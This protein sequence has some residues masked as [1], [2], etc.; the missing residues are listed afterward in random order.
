MFKTNE[1]VR[2]IKL[3]PEN[4][5][6]LGHNLAQGSWTSSYNGS[7]QTINNYITIQYATYT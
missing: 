7:L 1:V 6:F 4:E 2:K 5:Y 3:P